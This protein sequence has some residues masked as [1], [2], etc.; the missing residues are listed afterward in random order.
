[1][2][3]FEMFLHSDIKIIQI[4]LDRNGQYGLTKYKIKTN[5]LKGVQPKWEFSG[6]RE[7]VVRILG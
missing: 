2:C 5:F 7:G 1:M 4:H 3:V 6:R